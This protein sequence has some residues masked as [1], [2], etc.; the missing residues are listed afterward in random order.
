M[1]IKCPGPNIAVLLS[2]FVTKDHVNACCGVFSSYSMRLALTDRVRMA[3]VIN[4]HGSPK[5]EIQTAT[6]SLL[7]PSVQ[8]EHK[9]PKKKTIV[10]AA[11][12]S[13]EEA[14]IQ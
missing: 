3:I 12:T 7:L 13:P 10:P 2:G 5:S 14:R 6:A 4:F 11:P 8:A 1:G 9:G